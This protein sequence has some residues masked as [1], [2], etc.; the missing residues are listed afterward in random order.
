MCFLALSRLVHL[1]FKSILVRVSES[2]LETY[3]NMYANSDSITLNEAQK[4][5]LNKLYAIGFDA[6]IYK[7]KIDI[8]DYLLPTHYKQLRFDEFK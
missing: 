4:L 6:G 7:D 3:L 1:F 5:A 2:E 8:D